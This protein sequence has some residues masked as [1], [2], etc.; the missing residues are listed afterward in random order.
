MLNEFENII[1]GII[2]DSD[3]TPADHYKLYNYYKDNYDDSAKYDEFMSGIAELE[4][5]LL[6]NVTAKG[7]IMLPENSNIIKGEFRS[8]SKGFGFVTPLDDSG[9]KGDIY[10][11]QENTMNA[12]NGDIVAVML[13]KSNKAKYDNSKYKS[14]GKIIRII[15]HSLQSV[16][17]TLNK[18]SAGG[19][20]NQNNFYV[21]PD[22]PKIHLHVIVDNSLSR[23]V[24]AAVGSKV[25]IKITQYPSEN[26]TGPARAYGKIVH[27]FGNTE[28]LEANYNAIL[29]EHNIKLDFDTAAVEEAEIRASCPL[30]VTGRLDLRSKIIFTIDGEDAKDLDDAI[31]V[32]RTENGY[33]L[34]V[35][36]ADVS[37]YVK[38]SSA[39][40]IEAFTR[41]TSVYFADQVVPM[42]PQSLSNGICSLTSGHDRYALS[43]FITLSDQGEIIE[44]TL[45]ESIISTAVRGVYSE[46]NDIIAHGRN[47]Q[48]NEKYSMLMPD[49]LD[50][51]MELYRILDRN[52]KER[53]CLNFDTTESK[54]IIGEDNTVTDI[55]KR[56]RGI[57]ERV[58]EQ[59]MLCANEA[60]ANWLYWQ[61]MPCVYRTH[62][63]P[64]PEKIHEFS[65][66]AHN[67]G[68]NVAS[69]R[70]KTIHPSA[71]QK[72][73]DQAKEREID[74]IVSFVMLRSMMKAHYS[75]V[76]SPHFGLAIDMYCHFTSPIRRY[77]DLIVHRIV[78]L[79][80]HGQADE[81]TINEYTQFTEIAA[82]Q[83]SDTEVKAVMAER[84][85]EDLYKCVYMSDKVGEV[86][87]GII[88]SVMAFGFFVELDNTC[89]GLVPVS[90]LKGYFEFDDA[91]LRL[92]CGYRSYNL[93]DSVEVVIDKVD[94]IRR[95][96]D[97]SLA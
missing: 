44:C 36:I 91:S 65:I 16:I 84:D 28:T 78:K 62:D 86:F 93:S 35:H 38:P 87:T 8:S 50:L 47:S 14:V 25:E 85:I 90:S 57:T 94:I 77:P 51:V 42:L 53:G 43:A 22:D 45:S 95:R 54:I 20:K 18:M 2:S 30:T 33:I 71:L 26:T 80:L 37:E 64:S 3:Y 92:Y 83:S 70:T 29:Y 97:M 82:K 48:F 46:L 15:E 52:S 34:G 32:E 58:I 73:L 23:D 69:I 4:R 21:V 5:N 55:V 13:L 60:V 24:T 49:T 63:E 27:E 67:L 6:V 12:L 11:S 66:F 72:V 17:G 61:S 89:E 96:I 81:N 59:F 10:I 68:L 7:K 1:I 31:S 39:L 74:S 40:D 19:R 56:D 76:V 75:A 9:V 41:G 79:I 88:S